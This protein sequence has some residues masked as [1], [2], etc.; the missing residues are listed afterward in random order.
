MSYLMSSLMSSPLR[1]PASRVLST[2]ALSVLGTTVLTLLLLVTATAPSLAQYFGRNRVQ[3]ETFDYR[4][5]TTDRF[6][7]H[8][9]ADK[10][11][12]DARSIHDAGRMTERWNARI[13]SVMKHRLRG[14]KSVILYANQSDFHQTNIVQGL[15]EGT[16]GVTEGFRTRLIMPLT[17]SYADTDHVLGHEMVHVF[18]YD[19]AR[20]TAAVQRGLQAM[21]R[22]PLWFVEGMA[23]YLSIGSAHTQTAVWLRDALLHER[24][25]DLRDLSRRPDRYFPYRWGHAFWAYVAATRGDS[26]VP[27]LYRAS[28]ESGV[29]IAIGNRLDFENVTALS[30]EWKEAIRETYQPVL[31]GRERPED[32][33]TRILSPETSGGGMNLSPAL[34]PDGR[35]V[36]YLSEQGLFSIELFIADAETGE[37]IA[38]LSSSATSSHFNALRFIE[39]AGAWSPGGDLFAYPVVRKGRNEIAL[40]DVAER[41][42]RRRIHVPEVEEIN[43]IAW[44]PSAPTLVVSGL[45]EGQSDLFRI[46]MPS[47]DGRRGPSGGE[48]RVTRLTDDRYADLQPDFSPDGSRL[49]FT[50]DRGPGTSFSRLTYGPMRLGFLDLDSGSITTRAPFEE[51][52][53]TNPQFGP[54]GSLYFIGD[55]DG[56]PNVYRLQL[57][58]ERLYRVTDVAT[59]ITGITPLSPALTV[60]QQSGRVLVSVFEKTDYIVYGI[61]PE[62]ARGDLV[63]EPFE[64]RTAHLL[65]TDRPE[66]FTRMEDRAADTDAPLVDRL[67]TDAE[68]GLP[69]FRSFE[70]RAYRPSLKLDYVSG[71]GGVGVGTGGFFGTQVGASGAVFM[72]FSDEMGDHNLGTVLFGN[73]TVQDLGAYTYYLN[74]R[75]RWNWGGSAGHIP[76]RQTYSLFGQDPESGQSYVGLLD[77][78]QFYDQAAVFTAYPFDPYRRVEFETGF[79]RIGSDRELTRYFFPSGRADR[80]DIPSPDPIYLFETSAAFIGD[81]SIFGFASPIQG[82]RYHF[83]AQPAIGT[84]S[85]VGVIADAR[86]YFFARP[87]TIAARALHWAEYDLDDRRPAAYDNAVFVGNGTLIRGYSWRTFD[88]EECTGGLFGCPVF[89]RLIGTRALVA[90]LEARLPLLGNDRFG[91]L[92]FPYLP[93]ELTVFLDGALAWTEEEPPSFTLA[94]TSPE[95][96][97]VFSTGFSFRVNMFGYL[98]FEP[99]WAYPFQRPE[100]GSHWGLVLSPGW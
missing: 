72:S 5:L 63:D 1:N 83:E 81:R 84:F 69:G 90:N 58:D 18:Q 34:S 55:P 82:Y 94:E 85:T 10:F 9:T 25:P 14:R 6:D 22:L 33:G 39:S 64:E 44:S 28:L 57:E 36:A 43:H 27:D 70:G 61:G 97:P 91:L 31:D 71:Y 46:D 15:G 60:A 21:A 12:P 74:Q 32:T 41:T 30:N 96:I 48:D 87:L 42:V 67:L 95:R 47:A 100:K 79:L 53:H 93:T 80:I 66:G 49:V 78:R 40:F 17:G 37:T 62:N 16:G 29:E 86:K 20:D 4:V 45:A 2:E 3:Y 68:F 76:F 24:L 89:D 99:Y 88:A 52:T 23:E 77:E 92:N 13:D 56:V 11:P 38:Q 26:I 54:N 19:I 50:T 59:G 8:Y 51:G 75:R 7:V 98:I 73:G 35:Y 65:P